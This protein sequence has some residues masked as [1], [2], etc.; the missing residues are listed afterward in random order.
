M[1][2]LKRRAEHVL[3]V[4]G[5]A[6]GWLRVGLP[7]GEFLSGATN[8]SRAFRCWACCYA[9]L[10]LRPRRWTVRAVAGCSE[11]SC[12]VLR[13]AACHE[14]LGHRWRTGLEMG[15]V[16]EDAEHGASCRRGIAMPHVA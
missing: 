8:G 4:P 7:P 11:F 12:G 6:S 13:C 15:A 9:M 5:A 10:N 16:V 14:P 3:C 2:D 1:L